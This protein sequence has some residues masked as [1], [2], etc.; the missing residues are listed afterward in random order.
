MKEVPSPIVADSYVFPLK[1]QARFFCSRKLK[2]SP[3][4]SKQMAQK[5]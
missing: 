2:I 5:S 1:K 3:I 4:I